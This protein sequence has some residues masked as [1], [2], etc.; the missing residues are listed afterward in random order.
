M[1]LTVGS[2]IK[3]YREKIGMTLRELASKVNVTASFLSQVETG[4]AL[5]SLATL[6]KLADALH[7]TIGIIVGE[8]ES[9]M[10][11]NPIVKKEKRITLENIGHGIK[12]ELLATQD[13]NNQMQPY[14]ITLDIN[15]DTEINQHSGQESGLVLAGSIELFFNK[16]KYILGVGDN[17]YINANISHHLKNIFNVESQVLIVATPPLF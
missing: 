17:F 11:F 3:I 15:G 6:K 10:D 4:K 13:I 5:P 16:N 2:N 1:R 12:I 8:D 14:I 7:Q 9:I